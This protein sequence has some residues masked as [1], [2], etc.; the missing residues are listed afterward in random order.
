MVLH[1]GTSIPITKPLLTFTHRRKPKPKHQF[2]RNPS[3]FSCLVANI[4][5]DDI[6]QLAHNKVL[7]AA[8]ASAAIGQLS[9]P[10]TSVLLYGKDFDFKTAFQAGGFPSTHSSV[11]PLLPFSLVTLHFFSHFVFSVVAAATSLALERGFSDSIFGVTLV[12]AGLIMYD[13]Q[14]VRR[15][16]GNHARALNTMLPKVEVNSVVY[17]DRDNL[18]DSR[19]K[20][21]E[22]LGPILSKKSSS[23][24]SKNANVPLL[25]ASEKETRQ[26][27]EA[28]ASFEFVAND[29]EGLEGDANY[30]Q[31]RLKE[32]IGHTEVEVIAGALLGFVVSLAVY[33]IIT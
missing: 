3:K 20:S 15:E 25:I 19:E 4:G 6:V 21:S 14:G 29:Y 31:V 28:A 13:A 23:S 7:V 12:Y 22:R 18:I 2:S 30:R 32:S 9:K 24:T 26:T 16:V 10:F 17:E 27:K 33:S 11:M 1:C 5:V 8:A